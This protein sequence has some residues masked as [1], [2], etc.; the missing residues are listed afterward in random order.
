MATERELLEC[1]W[2]VLEG[3][4]YNIELILSTLLALGGESDDL[5]GFVTGHV[6]IGV[7]ELNHSAKDHAKG[8]EVSPG[9]DVVEL[10]LFLQQPG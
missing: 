6:A 5:V 4:V 10:G 2:L 9:W 3:L 8:Q 1:G 7:Q